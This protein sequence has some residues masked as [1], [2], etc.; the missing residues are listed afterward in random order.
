MTGCS[1]SRAN[2]IFPLPK[3]ETISEAEACQSI[4]CILNMA[5]DKFFESQLC[6]AKMFCDLSQQE[7][8][9]EQLSDARCIQA[10]VN[11]ASHGIDCAREHAVLALANLSC[12][13][14]C[15]VS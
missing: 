6:A 12:T 4:E 5:R 1:C 7:E 13:Q 11:I 8:M 2:A 10:L 3:V 14:S 15:Q 9:H